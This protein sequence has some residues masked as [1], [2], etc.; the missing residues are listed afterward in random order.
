MKIEYKM[1]EYRY[2][3]SFPWRM[4]PERMQ[5]VI[6]ELEHSLEAQDLM[7]DLFQAELQSCIEVYYQRVGY[8]IADELAERYDLAL[9][10]Y[11][12]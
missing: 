5:H 2:G 4:L 8:V 1:E 3:L 12:R 10:Q 7:D 6:D 11:W 9:P